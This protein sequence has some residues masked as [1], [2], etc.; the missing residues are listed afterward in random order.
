MPHARICVSVEIFHDAGVKLT[1]LRILGV[2]HLG[3]ALQALGNLVEATYAAVQLQAG[4]LAGLIEEILADGPA[5]VVGDIAATPFSLF[6]S[7]QAEEEFGFVA[8]PT[9]LTQIIPRA[10][11]STGCATH[12]ILREMATSTTQPILVSLQIYKN[13]NGLGIHRQH[14]RAR[15]T[16]TTTDILPF[17][18]EFT[19]LQKF[20]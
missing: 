7:L 15:N 8:R 1:L 18:V 20:T 13:T 12:G 4:L 10:R 11:Q 9:M 19:Q 6:A 17:N 2:L 3:H 14:S 16:T 5:G